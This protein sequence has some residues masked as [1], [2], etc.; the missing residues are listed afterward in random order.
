M[1][2]PFIIHGIAGGD[3][4]LTLN[5]FPNLN[6]VLKSKSNPNLKSNS[7]HVPKV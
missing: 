4:T 3:R 7:N 1:L 5:A 6:S 2:I